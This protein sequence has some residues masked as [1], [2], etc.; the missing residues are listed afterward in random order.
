MGLYQSYRQV[1][2]TNATN[3]LAE[4]KTVD[5]LAV[6]QVGILDGKTYKAV[7][8]PTY[9]KNKALYFVWGTPNVDAGD[10]GGVPNENEYTKLIKGKLIRGFRAKKAKR[11]QTPV[12]TIGWSGAASD[13]DTISGKVGEAKSLFV[14]LTGTV[15]DRLYDKQGVT[16]EF[17]TVPACIGD[18][19]NNCVDADPTDLAFQL[20][21]QIN[22][23]KD[24]KKFIKA[25]ALIQCDTAPA[26]VT[27]TVYKFILDVPDAGDA[28]SFGLVQSQYPNETISIDG[29]VGITTTY[30]VTKTA[31][32]AP[33]AFN[34]ESLL[35][36]ADCG[37]C[38]TGYT[39]NYAGN[40]F[41]VKITT[42][43]AYPDLSAA[44]ELSHTLTTAN[45]GGFDIYT[46]VVD[47]AEA[48]ADYEAAV[49]AANAAYSATFVEYQK[50]SCTITSPTTIAWVADGTLTTQD[51]DYN[52]TIADSVCGTNRLADLQAAYPDYTV[53]LVGAD[54]ACVNTYK[55][56]LTSEPYDAATCAIEDVVF[57]TLDL[58]EGAQWVAAATTA[59]SGNCKVGIQL[60][61]SFF[62]KSTNECS[63]NSF[64]YE[65][66]VVHIQIS[67][68]NPDFNAS[69]CEGEWAVKQIRQVEYPQGHGA[70]IQFLEKE[71]KQ[72]DQRFRSYD[73]VVREVQ[74]YSLQADPNKFY[75][76]YSLEFDTKFFTSG[77]WSEQYTE[78]FTL[79][80]FVPEGNGL[81]LEAAVN[82]YLQSAGVD[83]DGAVV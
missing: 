34:N 67:N 52:L 19:D 4:G 15:I 80:I 58:F 25:K 74:G 69:P 56:T 14:K 71:S 43:N 28:T 12:Y 79:D 60:E 76:Q 9:A 63:F 23:D 59:Y 54:G 72:Y 83:E 36:P 77:G 1:F 38:P 29:R 10:F 64:P 45:S 31:N 55:L 30:S 82:G 78:T 16:K 7:T 66:D 73:P 68:Y 37:A 5:S 42:G 18:C 24:F 47:V 40:V 13:T 44:K 57:P 8:A 21:D 33:A 48:Q 6:G 70:Y 81:A 35:I 11:G 50:E 49:V 26:P 17:V 27:H 75:D 53:S 20:V 51:K 62:H 61:T 22:N 2:V 3:L 39:Y 46:S 65:N 41:T 32:V